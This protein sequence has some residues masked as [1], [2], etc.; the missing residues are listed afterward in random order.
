M[1]YKE[2]P[3]LFYH[4]EIDHPLDVFCKFVIEQEEPSP[5]AGEASVSCTVPWECWGE[6]PLRDPTGHKAIKRLPR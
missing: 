2:N 6:T 4:W 5:M 1:K 3:S